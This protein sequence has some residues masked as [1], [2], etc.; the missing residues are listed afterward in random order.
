MERTNSVKRAKTIYE[1]KRRQQID[2]RCQK[3]G[4]QKKTFEDKRD[5]AKVTQ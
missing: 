2:V 4:R 5:N 1:G 3:M